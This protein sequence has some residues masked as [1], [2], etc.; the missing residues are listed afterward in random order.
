M[1]H[2]KIE[3]PLSGSD[4]TGS[5]RI[6]DDMPSQHIAAIIKAM[7]TPK[8]VKLFFYIIDQLPLIE[9]LVKLKIKNLSSLSTG[10]VT[11]HNGTEPR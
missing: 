5:K 11:F 3:P 2:N 8:T 9:S 7:P 6:F 10:L 4:Q 1:N